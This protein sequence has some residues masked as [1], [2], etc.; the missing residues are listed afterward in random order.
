MLGYYSIPDRGKIRLTEKAWWR[1][2][3]VSPST[4]ELL[5]YSKRSWVHVRMDHVQCFQC[6]G[7]C[8]ILLKSN[9]KLTGGLLGQL[10][11]PP[12]GPS[13]GGQQFLGRTFSWHQRSPD[14]SRRGS[15]A[16]LPEARG[17]Q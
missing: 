15:I 6:K 12:V 10:Q 8:G 4:A 13:E 7:K 9:A 5:R 14:T 16:L 11:N 3:H 2:L 1:N 17:Y